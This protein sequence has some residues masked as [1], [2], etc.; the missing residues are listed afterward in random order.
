[1]DS[2]KTNCTWHT[3]KVLAQLKLFKDKAMN[4]FHMDIV[5][6]SCT[7]QYERVFFSSLFVGSGILLKIKSSQAGVQGITGSYSDIFCTKLD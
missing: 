1:M 5:K 2:L 3:L 4:T 6:A 7:S